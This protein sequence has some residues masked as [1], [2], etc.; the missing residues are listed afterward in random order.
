MA[1]HPLRSGWKLSVIL[2][3]FVWGAVAINLFML[4]LGWQS[5]GIPALSPSHAMVIA[6]LVA[7]PFNLLCVRWIRSL[8]RQAEQ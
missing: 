4:G 8:I 1:Q 7:V 2:Y 3:P 6:V 5:L